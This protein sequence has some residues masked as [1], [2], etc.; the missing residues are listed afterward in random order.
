MAEDISERTTLWQILAT[1]S[2]LERA[3]GNGS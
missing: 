2:E 1:L 3:A